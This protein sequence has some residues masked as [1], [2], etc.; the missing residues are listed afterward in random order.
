MAAGKFCVNAV[1]RIKRPK[2]SKDARMF[3]L[4]SCFVPKTRIGFRREA[5]SRGKIFR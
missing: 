3:L 5:D 1:A 2:L 4:S